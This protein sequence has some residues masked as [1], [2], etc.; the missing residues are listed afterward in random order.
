MVLLFRYFELWYR[1][2]S[3]LYNQ[4]SSAS[5]NHNDVLALSE[6]YKMAVDTFF[7]ARS[8]LELNL[9]ADI[10]RQ[11][12]TRIREVAHTTAVSPSQENFLPPSDF[13][14]AYH[15]SS[16][17]LATSFK[18]FLKQ[19]A[20]NADRNRGWF[21]IFLGA[22]TWALGLIPTIV[23]AVLDKPR[24]WRC[25]GLPLWWFGVVVLVGGLKRTCLVIYLL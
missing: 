24:G 25:L 10:R 17:S 4:A 21:A 14:A 8:P 18:E 22:L 2:Y 23:C 11:L 3:Q 16:E 13:A 1:A 7:S 6:A 9:P 19:A 12:D 5:R 20:R 15:D